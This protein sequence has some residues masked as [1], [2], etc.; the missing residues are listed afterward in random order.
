MITQS[1]FEKGISLLQTH[2]NRELC[3]SAIAIWSEYLNEHLDDETF[4]VAVKQAVLSLDL[5]PSAKKLVEFATASRE[6]QAIADW[7][8]IIAAA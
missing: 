2:F 6:V 3:L 7:R 8:V 1:K 4:T 5:F